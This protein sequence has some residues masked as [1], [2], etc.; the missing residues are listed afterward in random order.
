[1]SLAHVRLTKSQ[2]SNASVSY[3]A[4]TPDFSGGDRWEEIG[5]LAIDKSSGAFKFE[6]S[7]LAKSHH[8]LPPEVFNLEDA[9]RLSLLS[10]AYE[11]FGWGAWSMRIRE[12][13]VQFVA[14]GTFPDSFPDLYLRENR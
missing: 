1:M 5:L 7:E 14:R 6:M 2:E 11:G 13:A 3:I 10:S 12:W 4:E 9:E 8:M